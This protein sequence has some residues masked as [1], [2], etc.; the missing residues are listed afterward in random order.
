[1]QFGLYGDA[2]ACSRFAQEVTLE[3]LKRGLRVSL[4]S[5][6]GRES[7]WAGLPGDVPVTQVPAGMDPNVVASHA[8]GMA[9]AAHEEPVRGAAAADITL[10][11]GFPRLA[12]PKAR[13]GGPETEPRSEFSF[14]RLEEALAKVPDVAAYLER[15]VKTE[16]EGAQ[17]R[18]TW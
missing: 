12:M 16:R 4:V 10:F 8:K 9:R 18:D 5:P 1:M 17:A 13:V 2:S 15:G 11:C 6:A 14:P 7:A 3:L